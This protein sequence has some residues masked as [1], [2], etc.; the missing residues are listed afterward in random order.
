M[1]RV[2]QVLRSPVPEPRGTTSALQTEDG[3]G[4]R[5]HEQIDRRVAVTP[6]PHP[7]VE[8]VATR[9]ETGVRREEG[10]A[11]CRDCRDIGDTSIGVGF[12]YA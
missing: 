6:V 1:F 2:L 3:T 4:R 12:P 5:S 8:H 9:L 7:V 11:R 10:A